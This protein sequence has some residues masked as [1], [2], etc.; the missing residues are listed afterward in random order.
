[1]SWNMT[2]STAGH[3][4]NCPTMM[5]ILMMQISVKAHMKRTGKSLPGQ[6]VPLLP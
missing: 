4:G 1:M 2:Y 6:W 5:M 3:I